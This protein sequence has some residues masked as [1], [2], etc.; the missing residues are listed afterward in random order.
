MSIVA[1]FIAPNDHAAAATRPRG[2]G[3]SYPSVHCRDFD[4]DDAV[5][6]WDMYFEDPGAE[7]P[8]L[9]QLYARQWPT[10]VAEVVNDGTGVFALP[11]Q[12]TRAL[13]TASPEDLDRLAIRWVERL[14]QVD[15]HSRTGDDPLEILRRVARLAATSGAGDHIY[16]WHFLND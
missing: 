7:L 4:A 12:L 2:P 9:E 13:A 8:P 6:E 5:V 15:G 1:F 10:W 11:D 16:C 14:R 3:D